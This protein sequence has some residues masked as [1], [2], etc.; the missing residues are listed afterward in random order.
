[1]KTLR[2]FPV[3]E[4]DDLYETQMDYYLENEP[5]FLLDYLF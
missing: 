3:V 5:D 2:D 4:I 1:M